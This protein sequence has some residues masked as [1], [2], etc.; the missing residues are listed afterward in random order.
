[1]EASSRAYG[2]SR[3]WSGFLAACSI[4]REALFHAWLSS[5]ISSSTDYQ[6]QKPLFLFNQE[7]LY[8]LP[9]NVI[10]MASEWLNRKTSMT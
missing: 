9:T 2:G 8:L 4:F 6:K 5:P 10:I 3:S 1:M 7:E